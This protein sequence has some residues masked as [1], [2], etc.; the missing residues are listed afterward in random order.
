MAVT[1]IGV[2]P[3]GAL[4]VEV[5]AGSLD[6]ARHAV[7]SPA[8]PDVALV[9]LELDPAAPVEPAVAAVLAAHPGAP[10]I[11]VSPPADERFVVAAMKAG[12]IGYL[13][14]E[15]LPARAAAAV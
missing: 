14:A 4:A 3:G 12:A 8:T 11:A 5:L 15:D 13:F 2:L 1:R 10:V 9:W 7:V 6:A